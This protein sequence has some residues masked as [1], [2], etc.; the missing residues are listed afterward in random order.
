MSLLNSET[1][2]IEIVLVG[3]LLAVIVCLVMDTAVEMNCQLPVD[4]I[5]SVNTQ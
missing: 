1:I 5:E 3:N 2:Y 4:W